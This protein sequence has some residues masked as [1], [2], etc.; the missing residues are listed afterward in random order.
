MEHATPFGL[1]F[2]LIIGGMILLSIRKATQGKAVEIKKLRAIEAIDEAIGQAVEKGRPISYTTGLSGIGPL[3]YASLGI[4]HHIARRVARFNSKLFVPCI[5]PESYILTE[6]TVQNAYRKERKIGQY[7]PDS[8]RFLADEQ[9]AYASGYMGLIHR[10]NVG[11]AF[12]M[13]SFAA[14]SLILAEAG[15]QIGAMQIAGTTSNEQIPFFVTT[16][17]YTLLGEELFAAGAFFSDN[18]VQKGSLRGQDLCKLILLILILAGS[19]V[20]TI[21]S[22]MGIPFGKILRVTWESLLN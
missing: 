4:L 15:N 20:G 12:L 13:G 19:F 2:I 9:F 17:D 10:E 8:V 18:P 14:E 1:L 5:D 3:L 22:A 16:C 7:Q 21:Y 6:A 11:S